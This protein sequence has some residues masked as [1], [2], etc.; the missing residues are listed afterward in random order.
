ML[1]RFFTLIL[2][3]FIFSSALFASSDHKQ[4]LKRC[5]YGFF[6]LTQGGKLNAAQ[7]FFA[8]SYKDPLLD[9]EWIIKEIAILTPSEKPL[10]FL[11][12]NKV[13]K[14]L[15]KIELSQR[16]REWAKSLGKIADES[17]QKQIQDKKFYRS[18]TVFPITLLAGP[19]RTE[20]EHRLELNDLVG[21]FRAYT[22]EKELASRTFEAQLNEIY[23]RFSAKTAE[24][25]DIEDLKRTKELSAKYD[26]QKWEDMVQT[27]I[28]LAQLFLYNSRQDPELAPSFNEK[29][30]K[31]RSILEAI[32]TLDRRFDS[33]QIDQWMNLDP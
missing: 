17:S 8:E 24:K 16:Q 3:F 11:I 32:K 18:E 27:I 4:N 9:R 12:W 6:N 20:I 33:A 26:A 14:S 5:E 28:D 10:Q 15:E 25:K 22:A 23:R 7:K 19:Q 21:H 30:A 31:I 13:S 2:G 29:R 1:S